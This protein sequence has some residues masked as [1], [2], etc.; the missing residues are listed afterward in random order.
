MVLLLWIGLHN[1]Q[2]LILSNIWNHIKRKLNE[3]E[4]P[5]NSL[6]QL[7]ERVEKEWDKIDKSICQGLIESMPRHIAAVLKANGGYTKY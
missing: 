5:L 1:L 3:Y 2:I 6:H 7:W 4:N